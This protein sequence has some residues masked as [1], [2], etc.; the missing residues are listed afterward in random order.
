MESREFQDLLKAKTGKTEETLRREFQG[1]L[2]LHRDTPYIQTIVDAMEYSFQAGGKRLRP[3]LMRETFALFASGEDFGTKMEPGGGNISAE[4]RPER[5][6][7]AAAAGLD[8][9]PRERALHRFMTALEMIHTYSL[10]HDDLPAMDNDA[11]RRGKETTWKVYGDGM[12]VLAGD[13][14]LNSAFEIGYGAILDALKDGGDP[15]L[16]LRIAR[17]GELLSQKAGVPG[18]LGGQAADVEAEKQALPMTMDRILFIHTNKTAALI[19]AAMGIGAILGGAE[20]EQLELVTETARKVGIAFQIQ[21]DIL[22]VTGNSAELGKPVGS[23]EA[24]GKETYVTLMGLKESAAEVE[25]LSGEAVRNLRGLPGD[26]EFLEN[27]IQYLVYR[28]K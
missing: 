13:A 10:V 6:A 21:D 4:A 12:G 5:K 2:G 17:C 1:Y 28:K 8:L 3:L 11:F 22:D 9:L 23:D 24:S 14:L 15:D 19:E 26:H 7:Q 18:M 27:L 25:R 20:P 16:T